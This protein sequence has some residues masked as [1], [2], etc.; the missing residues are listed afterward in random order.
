M[1][2]RLVYIFI[3]LI[4]S[5]ECM[6]ASRYRKINF[7]IDYKYYE[8]EEHSQYLVETIIYLKSEILVKN[9]PIVHRNILDNLIFKL[10]KNPETKEKLKEKVIEK[11]NQYFINFKDNIENKLRKFVD[12]S[13]SCLNLTF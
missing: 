2:K 7:Y 4:T 9:V 6:S 1:L 10:E 12:S 11:L 13:E 3:L 8:N 5:A